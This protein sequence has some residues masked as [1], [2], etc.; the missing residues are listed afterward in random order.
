MTQLEQQ[1]AAEET[2]TFAKKGQFKYRVEYS[3]PENK[4]HCVE[5][6][7]ENIHTHTHNGN[8]DEPN[9]TTDLHQQQKGY[10][11]EEEESRKPFEDEEAWQ[12]AHDS[13][14]YKNAISDS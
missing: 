9:E 3:D 13:G 7:E 4:E 6:N 10:L 11:Q 12:S 2:G 14:R 8:E 1:D 5:E